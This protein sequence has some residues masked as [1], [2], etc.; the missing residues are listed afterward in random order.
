L[1]ITIQQLLTLMPTHFLIVYFNTISMCYQHTHR[2]FKHGVIFAQRKLGYKP[3]QHSNTW[4]RTFD[5]LQADMKLVLQEIIK[6]MVA[7]IIKMI[8]R[9]VKPQLFW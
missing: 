1:T 5:I 9:S 6:V 4:K 2:D 7:N 8:A 3:D